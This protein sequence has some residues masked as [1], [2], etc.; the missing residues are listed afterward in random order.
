MKKI[1][2]IAAALAVMTSMAFS[3]AAPVYATEFTYSVDYMAYKDETLPDLEADHREFVKDGLV[4]NIYDDF[5]YL[6]SCEDTDI[7]DA[8][9]PEEADGVPVVGLT[10]TPFGYCRSLKSVTL[11]DT[12]KYID[13]LDLA[14]SSGKVSTD[15]TDGEILPTLEKVTV[16]ENNPYF[17]SENGIIYSKDM[18]ELIGCPPAMEMKEL[19]ISEK[20][21]AIKD[22]AF[23]ACY[24][25]E[26]AVIPENIKHIHNSAFVACK[27]L[28]SVEIPSGVTVL[29]GDAFFGCSS[30]SEVKINSK[31]EKIG[32]GAFSGCTSLKEFTIPETVSVIGHG[33]FENTGCIETV[34]GID[35]VDNWA[36]DG[37]SNSLKD[38]AIR[39][40][41]RGVAEFAFL[42]CNKTEHLS[43]PDSIMYTL[44]LCYASSKGPA[45][46]IDFSGHSIGERAFTGAKKLTDI[47]IY[48]RE[49]DIFDD[50]KTIPE[51]FKEPTE[52]ADDLIIDSGSYDNDKI[53]G[54]NSHS[55]SIQGPSGSELVIDEELL[56]E[57]PYTA[58]PVITADEETKD[59]RVTIHGYIGSTAE[60]YAKK[61]N[62]K[63]QPIDEAEIVYGD[64]NCSGKVDLSDAVLIMQYISNPDV[65]GLSGTAA[66]HMTD[67]GLKN[68]DVYG[69]D[70]ITPKDALTI[71]RY[72]LGL[73]DSLPEKE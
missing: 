56:E 18:K 16:S 63:F 10:D 24:K 40:G 35:Y 29:S 30:L 71:Q 68:G 6:V 1:I 26:K 17:A 44:P 28:K 55:K 2:S 64:A 34:D 51:T 11:P 7:T 43:F 39:E 59:N 60:A 50:E 12:M 52:L 45:V 15:K 70:G 9:I 31:L 8:V 32:F 14:A 38:A 49:C 58:S 23:A 69:G 57:M 54:G 33:A 73:I 21:E 20:A 46:T 61:Y 5:A 3:T 66:L 27:N 67:A 62:R 47:Y 25:M 48:D 72:M 53:S 22:F 4:F 41:T 36:V 19:K 37:D 65:Y 13:W 42:L